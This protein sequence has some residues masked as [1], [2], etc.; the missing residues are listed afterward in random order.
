MISQILLGL[1]L[2]MGQVG[3]NGQSDD[4]TP[5]FGQ[6]INLPQMMNPSPFH[7]QEPMPEPKE[8]QKTDTKKDEPA[9][10]DDG[11]FVHRFFKA[12]YDAFESGLHRDNRL[13]QE[14][15]ENGDDPPPAERRGLPEPWSSPPFPGHEFQGYP[16]MGVPRDET[17]YP[18]MKAINGIE[19]FGIGDFM[20]DNHLKVYGWAT[21]SGNFSTA[22]QT[23]SPTSYWIVPNSFQ[24]D[25]LVLRFER[26]ADTV[27]TTQWDWG[28]RSTFMYGED[29]RYTTA[30]GWMS[31]QL[32]KNNRLYGLDPIEQYFDVYV[33][34]CFRGHGG[35]RRPLGRL[36]GHRNATGSRQLHGQPFAP[37]HL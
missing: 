4:P 27:Q 8:P 30:G 26:E 16:L 19:A 9:V 10:Q 21:A 3:P 37:V 12:Y 17:V 34:W 33:P 35:S 31:D 28:F 6:V 36:S 2:A 29:Y 11:G 15:K 23:N 24:L 20:K 13:H 22:S 7:V 32:L 5:R 14:K 25:Q 18:L 1:T